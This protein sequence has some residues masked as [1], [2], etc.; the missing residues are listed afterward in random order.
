M[1]VNII[2]NIPLEDFD[3][4]NIFND[5][6]IDLT[7]FIVLVI[8]VDCCACAETLFLKLLPPFIFFFII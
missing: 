2:N 8:G 5:L 3:S 1:N 6:T 4:L 7:E